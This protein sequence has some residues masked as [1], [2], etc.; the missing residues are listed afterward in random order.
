[1]RYCHFGVSPVNYSDSVSVVLPCQSSICRVVDFPKSLNILYKM[2]P[3]RFGPGSFRPGS[4]RPGSFRPN[5][6]VGRFGLDRWVD[7]AQGRFGPGSFRPVY[8]KKIDRQR[9][10]KKIGGGGQV[11]VDV[12]GELK[13]LY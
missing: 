5:F 1:M 7:S 12:N 2:N 8:T 11:R 9:M 3:G 10:I 4:F 13:F 6:E